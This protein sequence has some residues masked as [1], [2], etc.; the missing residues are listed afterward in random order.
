MDNWNQLFKG[1][2][3]IYLVDS[4]ILIINN[5]DPLSLLGTADNGYFNVKM[6]VNYLVRVKRLVFTGHAHKH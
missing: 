6:A 4:A 3:M 1:W 2:I 5:R